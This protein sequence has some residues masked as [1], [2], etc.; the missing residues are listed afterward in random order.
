M[1][2]MVVSELKTLKKKVYLREQRLDSND[3]KHQR[4]K[5]WLCPD[6]LFSCSTWP[7]PS[8]CGPEAAPLGWIPH[9]PGAHVGVV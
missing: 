7:E 9:V 5:P 8:A 4:E 1:P 6:Q 2:A 3:D